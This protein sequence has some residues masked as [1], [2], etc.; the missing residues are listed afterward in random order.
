MISPV[1]HPVHR[2][3]QLRRQTW[4]R[5]PATLPSTRRRSS[6]ITA[7]Q[8]RPEVVHNSDDFQNGHFGRSTLS[9]STRRQSTMLC[10]DGNR[11]YKIMYVGLTHPCHP[12]GDDSTGICI[13]WRVCSLDHVTTADAAQLFN[14]TQSFMQSLKIRVNR[15]STPSV[16]GTEYRQTNLHS[17]H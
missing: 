13:V 3:V 11:R 1:A 12:S 2:C 4:S 16:I 6:A 9:S 14:A 5:V 8:R 15:C 10:R 7:E 17:P